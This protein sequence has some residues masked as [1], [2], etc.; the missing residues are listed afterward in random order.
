MTSASTAVICWD[1]DHTL[2]GYQAAG[3]ATGD[4]PFAGC[5]VRAGIEGTLER[6]AGL[7][8]AHDITT[9]GSRDYVRRALAAVGAEALL[10]HFAHIFP[11]D[12]VSA[13]A[14]KCYQPVAQAHGLTA[15]E[16]SARLIV[17]GDLA[18]DEPADLAGVVFIRQ[19]NG[20][21]QDPRVVEDLIVKLLT[22]GAGS[23]YAGF[24][25]MFAQACAGRHEIPYGGYLAEVVNGTSI[26][27]A[28][29]PPG[30]QRR[31]RLGAVATPT[32]TLL[33]QA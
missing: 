22:A 7:G 19:P 25:E 17:I 29:R 27:C 31:A 9:G 4:S 24:V 8:Y 15:K 30:P 21:R 14:G 12:A 32:I 26:C 16:A 28:E 23:L 11:G 6:L 10:R 18:D 1:F 5:G 33:A 2:F 13:G 20:H 3:H